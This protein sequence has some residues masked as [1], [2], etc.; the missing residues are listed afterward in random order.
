MHAMIGIR[1]AVLWLAVV[2]LG[3]VPAGAFAQPKLRVTFT[4][5]TSYVKSVAFSPDGKTRLRAGN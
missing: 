1:P 4:G 5:H 2:L 3:M